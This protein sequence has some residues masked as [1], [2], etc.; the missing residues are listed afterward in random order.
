M[1]H[2]APELTDDDMRR[3]DEII[4]AAERRDDQGR[5]SAA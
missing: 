1:P 2:L 5:C 4:A 3:A